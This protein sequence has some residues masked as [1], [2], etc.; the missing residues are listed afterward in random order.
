MCLH[1]KSCD[2]IQNYVNTKVLAV[3]N[4]TNND[5]DRG[6]SLNSLLPSKGMMKYTTYMFM[7]NSGCPIKDHI[8][9]LQGGS[10]NM[11]TDYIFQAKDPKVK[12]VCM[13]YAKTKAPGPSLFVVVFG[14]EI[15]LPHTWRYDMLCSVN[16]RRDAKKVNR[17]TLSDELTLVAQ[18]YADRMS[19]RCFYGHFDPEDGKSA[20]S[21]VSA[22]FPHFVTIRENIC[23]GFYAPF[24]AQ[25]GWENS[26]GHL[27]NMTASDVDCA[28]FGHAPGSFDPYVAPKWV[29]LFAHRI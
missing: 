4:F 2:A 13:G 29:A 1:V 23:Q 14:Y 7:N 9:I 27:K 12:V 11:S 28:G 20:E 10:R 17:V 25:E 6:L 26:P 22:K 21:R 18:Q 15:L 5:P 19:T 3:T 24:L 8:A 16:W